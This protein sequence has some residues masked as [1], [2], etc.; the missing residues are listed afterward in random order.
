[1]QIKTKKCP[2]RQRLVT[3]AAL[4]STDKKS[5]FGILFEIKTYLVENIVYCKQLHKQLKWIYSNGAS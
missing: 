5:P 4:S 2:T 1:M 3:T